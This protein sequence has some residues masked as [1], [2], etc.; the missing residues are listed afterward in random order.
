MRTRSSTRMGV[1]G[2]Y[3]KFGLLVLMRIDASGEHS[4][5]NQMSAEKICQQDGGDGVYTSEALRRIGTEEKR[6]RKTDTDRY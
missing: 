4:C 2:G 6:E 3:V 1:L 5:G